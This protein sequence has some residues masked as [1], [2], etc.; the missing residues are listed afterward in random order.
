MKKNAGFAIKYQ[1]VGLPNVEQLPTLEK[2]LDMSIK[3]ILRDLSKFKDAE[4]FVT[5]VERKA[6]D[7]CLYEI[8]KEPK[9]VV[10][11]Q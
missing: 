7:I 5:H 2:S 1:T 11:V 3:D 10:V 6:C 9:V 4:S 8:G